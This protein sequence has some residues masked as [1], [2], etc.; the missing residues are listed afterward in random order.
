MKLD[1][2]T[3]DG[4][5]SPIIHRQEGAR[6]FHRISGRFDATRRTRDV[7]V[8]IVRDGTMRIRERNP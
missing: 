7:I 4:V 8:I 3:A 5:G 2:R 6:S 1:G